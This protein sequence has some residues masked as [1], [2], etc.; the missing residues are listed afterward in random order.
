MIATVRTASGNAETPTDAGDWFTVADLARRIRSSEETAREIIEG[1]EGFIERGLVELYRQRYRPT[2]SGLALS[3]A[4][5][6]MALDT[7]ES[8][9]LIEAVA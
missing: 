7:S 5:N 9:P 2:E 4:L 6:G 3:R 1:P 8:M